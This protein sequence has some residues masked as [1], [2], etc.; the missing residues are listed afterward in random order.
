MNFAA[1]VSLGAALVCFLVALHPFVTYPLSLRLLARIRQRQIVP[2]VPAPPLSVA[3]CVCAYNEARV[4]A[5]RI[6]NLLALRQSMP[7]L[8][9]LV[10]VDAA[11]DATAAI[12]RSYGNAITL[13]E[14]QARLGKTH[15]MNTLV[16]MTRADIVVFSD[17]NVTFAPDALEKLLA[18]FADAAVG[19]VC[20]HL[21]YS[22][23][24]GETAATGSLYW[25]LEEHI[26]ALESAT[27]SVMGADGSIFA[28]RRALHVAPPS[29]LID[30]MFVSLSMLCAGARIVRQPD[31]FAFEDAVA[32]QGEEFHRKIRI[33]CQAF[34]VNRVLWPSLRLL[35]ALDFYKYVSHKLLRWLT[36]YF[37]A[38]ACLFA[39][40]G[41]AALQ[42][43]GLLVAAGLA[44]ASSGAFVGYGDMNLACRLREIAAAFIATG[45]GVARSWRG[46]QFQTWT[47]PASSRAAPAFQGGQA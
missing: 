23:A 25:R 36:V 38:A 11:S 28:I 19:C 16:G 2:T 37:L 46:E 17:A 27:G 32:T 45:I 10:Y 7:G 14:A 21:C 8:E 3:V 18:P 34:N 33:A 44:G 22:Q 5:G 9:I 12:A 4:I 26:K 40:I 47:P 35:P 6:E 1:F 39:A 29:H 41:L 31:A 24:G 42:A 30:D 43:W 13:V 20:G 15:G